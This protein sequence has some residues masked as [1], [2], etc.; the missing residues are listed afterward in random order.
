[1]K[2]LFVIFASIALVAAFAVSASATEWSLYGNARMATFIVD[3]DF[4]DASF[5]NAIGDNDDDDLQW[6]L[7]GNSRVGANIKGDNIKAQ[8]EYGTGVNLRRLYGIYDFGG[9]SLKIGQDYGPLDQFISGQVFGADLGLLAV[10]TFY[11]LRRQR[12]SFAA[13]DFVVSLVK[14]G[15]GALSATSGTLTQDVDEELPTIE[16]IGNH[17]ST[18]ELA[19]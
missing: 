16:A 11:G 12:I 13:G 5:N 6:D 10:G 7:Q 1:M 8:F 15:S 14:P 2:K 9:W 3:Q 18:V 4:G 17:V 19:P